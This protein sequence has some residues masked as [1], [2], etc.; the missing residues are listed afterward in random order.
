MKSDI[1]QWKVKC[2]NQEYENETSDLDKSS[3]EYLDNNS[4]AWSFYHKIF[5]L[6][7]DKF[8]LEAN[9]DT[10]DGLNLDGI[11]NIA[12]GF[13]TFFILNYEKNITSDLRLEK[14]C[15]ICLDYRNK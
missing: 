2:L 10:I 11:R 12:E 13:Y 8:G 3:Q 1:A 4:L 15:D 5:D 7:N 6:I 9:Q 14:I